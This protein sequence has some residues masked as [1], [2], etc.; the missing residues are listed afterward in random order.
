MSKCFSVLSEKTSG[1]ISKKQTA[2]STPAVKLMI[3]WSLSLF[4]IPKTPPE[5]VEINVQIDK[6]IAS[7]LLTTWTNPEKF[8]TM[9]FY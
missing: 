6:K 5:K 4:L 7:I 9:F 8:K 1:R 2:T 3:K